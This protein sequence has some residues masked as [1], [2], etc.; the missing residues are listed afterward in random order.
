MGTDTFLGR[1]PESVRDWIVNHYKSYA[2][3]NVVKALEKGDIKNG[4]LNGCTF[5]GNSITIGSALATPL[6]YYQGDDG[7]IVDTSEWIVCGFNGAVPEYV[8]YIMSGATR[9][10]VKA[11]DDNNIERAI[12]AGDIVYT[13][14]WNATT[15]AYDYT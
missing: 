5:S 3:L 14:A 4:V 10:F 15:N 2:W 11:T 12:A 13:R 6:A 7:T 1:P 9:A 8:K